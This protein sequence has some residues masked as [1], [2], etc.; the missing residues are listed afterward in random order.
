MQKMARKPNRGGFSLFDAAAGVCVLAVGVALAGPV[1]NRSVKERMG[2]GSAHN[3]KV[4]GLANSMYSAANA[5]LIATYTWRGPDF[6]AGE[7]YVYYV[8]PNGNVKRARSDFEA[9][10]IQNQAILMEISGRLNGGTQIRTD[11]NT[12]VHRRF[13]HLILQ[14]FMGPQLSADVFVDP[15]DA[16]MVD[17]HANPL[18]YNQGSGVPYA[19]DDLPGDGYDLFETW[20]SLPMRQRWAFST[21]YFTVPAAWNGSNLDFGGV[22]SPSE[23]SMHLMN[24]NS[25]V[26]HIQGGN[27]MSDVLFPSSKVFIH[28]EY[29]RRRAV[30]TNY[31]YDF[32]RPFKLMFDGSL[33]QRASGQANAAVNPWTG[34]LW[35]QPYVPLD[36]YPA[37]FGGLGD[38]TPVNPRYRWTLNGLSGVDYTP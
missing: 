7:E 34:E 18:D 36:T 22:Y 15:A 27:T 26:G 16:N 25:S 30:P 9:A 24:N 10:A 3:L 12:L 37:P 11:F 4:Q 6:N 1:M 29:D 13:V 20:Y 38:Q 8:L 21:S 32:A 23:S 35:T 5:D 19:P 2:V 17:W 31:A 14:D 33:N 28:E